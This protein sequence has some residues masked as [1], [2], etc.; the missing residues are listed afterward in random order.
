[1]AV[2]DGLL[3]LKLFAPAAPRLQ[4]GALLVKLPLHPFAATELGMM[5]LLIRPLT[6]DVES[7]GLPIPPENEIEPLMN[8]ASALPAAKARATPMPPS[9]NLEI[10]TAASI[11]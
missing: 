2:P 8:A 10:F 9:N 7:P 4:A 3:G 11:K 6:T 1:M 5:V